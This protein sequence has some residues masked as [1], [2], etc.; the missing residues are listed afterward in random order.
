MSS[1]VENIQ[2]RWRVIS[3]EILRLRRTDQP[4]VD[5]EQITTLL[6]AIA[7]A[8]RPVADGGVA[9]RPAAGG[10]AAGGAG[11]GGPPAGGQ[12]GGQGAIDALFDGQMN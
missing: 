6:A 3:T 2:A 5:Q 7:Q 1:S 8:A 11:G 10:A 9:N 4:Q 12:A